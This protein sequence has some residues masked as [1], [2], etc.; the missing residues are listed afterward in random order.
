MRS[1]TLADVIEILQKIYQVHLHYTERR[2]ESFRDTL[3][4]PCFSSEAYSEPLQTSKT[5]CFCVSS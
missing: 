4:L 3:Q 1:Q 2:R 5:E